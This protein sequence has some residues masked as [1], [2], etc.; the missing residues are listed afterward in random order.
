MFNRKSF[1]RAAIFVVPDD[2][3]KR[4]RMQTRELTP[5]NKKTYNN[6]RMVNIMYNNIM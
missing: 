3:K 6:V 4:H 2:D 5:Q 1:Y